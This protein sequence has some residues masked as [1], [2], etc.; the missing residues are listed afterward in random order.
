MAITGDDTVSLLIDALR[1]A[2]ATQ[3]HANGPSIKSPLDLELEPTAPVRTE[4]PG[5]SQQPTRRTTPQQIATPEPRSAIKDLFE[6]KQP[7]PSHLPLILAAGGLLA[8][9]GGAIYLWWATSQHSGIQPP[10]GKLAPVVL[11]QSP[12]IERQT[13][14]PSVQSVTQAAPMPPQPPAAHGPNH[15][16]ETPPTVRAEVIAE[17]GRSASLLED[18]VVKRSTLP[19]STQNSP[20]HEAHAAY[21]QGR[22]AEAYRL[23]A[24]ILR[25]DPN[26]IESLNAMA[27]IALRAGRPEEAERYLRQALRADPKD[28]QAR[29]QLS[30]LYSEGDPATAESRLRNLLAEQPES[31]PALFALGSIYARAGRWVEAQQAF[32]Q[33][34][35]LDQNNADT[36]YNLAVAL[37]HLQ[38]KRLAAQYYERAAAIA[39]PG[40]NA[41]DPLLARQR[42]R[43][44]S[45]ADT[46]LKP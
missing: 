20:T 10:S 32:F 17:P 21:Q 4:T 44:L 26:N 27:M 25:K 31:A 33:A 45:E 46:Q 41:F 5:T 22:L 18:G 13:S 12:S 38:Q 14:R 43:T 42:A 16:P 34:H 23:Y 2:E 9:A 35:T 37:D 29:S 11:N 39:S 36:L 7:A 6:L 28:A 1:Q 30:L 15:R 8:L 19:V 3:K 40:A 24:D